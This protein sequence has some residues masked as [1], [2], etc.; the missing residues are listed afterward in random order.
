[1]TARSFTPNTFATLA[2]VAV[3]ALLLVG[4]AAAVT[5]AGPKVRFT[6]LPLKAA[7]GA[8][9][10][11]AVKTAGSARC[12][13]TVRYGDGQ[14]QPG[15]AAARARNGRASWT[16]LVPDTASTGP[17]KLVVACAGAGQIVGAMPVVAGPKATYI[18]VAKRGFSQRIRHGRAIASWGLELKNTSPDRDALEVVVVVN[19]VDATNT[20]LDTD[21]ARVAGIRAGNVFYVGG[22]KTVP[23][24]PID[25]VEVVVRAGSRAPKVVHEPPVDDVRILPGSDGYVAAAAGQVANDRAG[26]LLRSSRIHAVYFDAA[27]NI[28]GGSTGLATAPLPTGARSFFKASL[29]AD[30][31]PMTRAATVRISVEPRFETVG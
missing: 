3:G 19:F 22:G 30:A 24:T 8:R 23:T 15:L 21:T 14:L 26:Q 11:V 12:T 13:L 2:C 6:A 29:Y 5:D 18:E 9:A 25:R 20:V 10:T 16:W 17:A 28:S 31:V 7:Q 1:M 27:G 4:K